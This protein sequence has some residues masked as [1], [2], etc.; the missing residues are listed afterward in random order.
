MFMTYSTHFEAYSFE[1]QHEFKY[2]I[3]W[4]QSMGNGKAYEFAEMLKMLYGQ[5][6]TL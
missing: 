6:N 3:D 4:L 2:M 5:F 1:F